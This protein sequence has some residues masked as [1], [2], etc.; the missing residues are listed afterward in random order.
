MNQN[1]II[2]INDRL[3]TL[4]TK[5]HLLEHKVLSLEKENKEI[6]ETINKDVYLKNDT[7]LARRIVRLTRSN[8]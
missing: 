3:K 6:K 1:T 7:E 8:L 5:V 2:Q 4:T